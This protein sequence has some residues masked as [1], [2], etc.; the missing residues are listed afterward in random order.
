MH[1]K[2][3]LHLTSNSRRCAIYDATQTQMMPVKACDLFPAML[4]RRT[5]SLEHCLCALYSRCTISLAASSA[6]A[7]ACFIIT[8]VIRRICVRARYAGHLQQQ[9]Q[10]HR[11]GDVMWEYLRGKPHTAQLTVYQLALPSPPAFVL[12]PSLLAVL[13]LSN[14]PCI[15]CESELATTSS[16]LA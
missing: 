10:Q 1:A 2:V 7:A 16:C 9:Q 5:C 11:S 3:P 6:A 14:Q 13:H 8:V 4:L 12:C 15:I